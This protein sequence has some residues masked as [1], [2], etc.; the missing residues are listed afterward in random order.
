MGGFFSFVEFL[1]VYVV[2]SGFVFLF[3]DFNNGFELIRMVE[4][5]IVENQKMDV[6]NLRVEVLDE[7]MDIE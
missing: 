7:L 6:S 4:I 5:F 3:F 1:V 2:Q